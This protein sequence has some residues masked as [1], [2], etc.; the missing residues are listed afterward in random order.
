MIDFH[1]HVLPGVDDGSRNVEES[2]AM[3]SEM[4]SQGVKTVV[5]TPHFYANDER[6][7]E[8]IRRR[9]AAREAL[10]KEWDNLPKILLG[11]EVRY[12]PGISR[13]EG[14]SLLKVEGSRLLLLEMPFSRWTEYIVKELEDLAG[15]GNITV[16]LAHI[17]RYIAMQKK[18]TLQ[19]LLRSGVLFQCNSSFFVQRIGRRKAIRM[20]RNGEI[21]F[22][23]SDCH[24]ME[25]RAPNLNM[26]VEL[27]K[28]RFG[29]SFTSDFVGFGN[30]LFLC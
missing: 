18:E 27:L 11:A 15:C 26:A 2:I 19:R 24:N 10:A 5:A 12:Y 28:K 30:E 17:E 20:M 29:D 9:N 4:N 3:L 8:F 23:G 22:L 14:L 7:D 13:L 16:V 1:A 21:H 6:V 25:D